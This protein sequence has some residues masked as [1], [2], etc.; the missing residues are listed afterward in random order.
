MGDDFKDYNNKEKIYRRGNAVD[1]WKGSLI[2]VFEA[3]LTYIGMGIRV[4]CVSTYVARLNFKEKTL[5]SAFEDL[6]EDDR[7]IVGCANKL[8]SKPRIGTSINTSSQ[9]FYHE[10]VVM[11]RRANIRSKTL[12]D[13]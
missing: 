2:D 8:G 9:R 4:V 3:Q 12:N 11:L 5:S 13:F 7:R 6:E 1:E 10:F